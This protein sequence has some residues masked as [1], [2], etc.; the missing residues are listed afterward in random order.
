MRRLEQATDI[1]NAVV[2]P[3]SLATPIRPPR[4]D[5]TSSLIQHVSGSFTERSLDSEPHSHDKA[6]YDDCDESL[7]G[8]YVPARR[9]YGSSAS[10]KIRAKFV[11]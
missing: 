4:L 7:E 2:I 3:V 6:G 11:S 10:A 5:S 9:L 8:N 1:G